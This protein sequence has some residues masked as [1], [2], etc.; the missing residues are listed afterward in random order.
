MLARIKWFV[1]AVLLG[2]GAGFL[3]GLLRSPQKP[4][5][6]EVSAPAVRQKDGSEQAKKVV[7]QE[8]PKVPHQL[9]AGSRV[10]R[11]E[12][13]TLTPTSV[14]GDKAVHVDAT[15]FED[16]EGQTHLITS[17]PDGRTEA[18]DTVVNVPD[19]VVTAEHSLF[20]GYGG[21]QHYIVGYTQKLFWKLHGGVAVTI[22]PS[23]VEHA[24]G[25]LIA[26]VNW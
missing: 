16:K 1:V 21:Q 23:E 26:Q 20:G 10:L 25:Y 6:V 11:A 15:L 18:T 22:T 9:P 13:I 14:L 17:S 4:A 3:L 19:R 24:R 12:A 8:A 7:V 5:V 2:I